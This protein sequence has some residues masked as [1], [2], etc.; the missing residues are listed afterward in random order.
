MDYLEDQFKVLNCEIPEEVCSFSEMKSIFE[1]NDKNLQVDVDFKKMSEESFNNMFESCKFM[2]RN[3]KHR[4]RIKS[5]I[6]DSREKLFYGVNNWEYEIKDVKFIDNSLEKL[7]QQ[8]YLYSAFE[9]DENNNESPVTSFA[10]FNIKLSDIISEF[11]INDNKFDW[12]IRDINILK[13]STNENTPNDNDK[14]RVSE[15][16]RINSEKIQKINDVSIKRKREEIN[17]NNSTASFH[18]CV[19]EGQSS[20]KSTIIKYFITNY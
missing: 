15:I 6:E 8:E 11:L 16:A 3:L 5:K 12:K 10:E 2:E 17:C 7:H 13:K 20:I 14:S 9:R 4:K 19:D 1:L 18:P